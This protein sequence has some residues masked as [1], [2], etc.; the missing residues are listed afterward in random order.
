[1]FEVPN[2]PEFWPPQWPS[3]M[4]GGNSPQLTEFRDV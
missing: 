3:D 1:M 2:G 4:T